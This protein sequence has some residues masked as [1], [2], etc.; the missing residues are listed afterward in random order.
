M[1]CCYLCQNYHFKVDELAIC[2]KVTA[3]GISE[4]N[5]KK[6]DSLKKLSCTYRQ[7]GVKNVA[8][9]RIDFILPGMDHFNFYACCP[10][11]LDFFKRKIIEI[12]TPRSRPGQII[13]SI[14]G[15]EIRYCPCCRAKLQLKEAV[16]RRMA[17]VRAKRAEKAARR[18]PGRPRK[19]KAAE[20]TPLE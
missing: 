12:D 19:R 11:V 8:F 10:G 15:R 2:P 18:S 16:E 1:R 4:E 13:Y 5:A 7:G 14:G 20:E 9:V 6:P 3:L 17:G